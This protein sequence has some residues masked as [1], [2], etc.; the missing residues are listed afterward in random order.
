MTPEGFLPSNAVLQAADSD[1][2]V[3]EVDVLN[4][5]DRGLVDPQ[6]VVIDQ[7]KEGEGVLYS[8]GQCSEERG[9]FCVCYRRSGL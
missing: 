7:T 8:K 3:L 5:D 2:V 4:R 1:A 9:G 6:A